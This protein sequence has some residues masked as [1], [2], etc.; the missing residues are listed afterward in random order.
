[1]GFMFLGILGGVIVGA[2]GLGA[3][4]D[5]LARRRG[6]SVTVS[7]PESSTNARTVEAALDPTRQDRLGGGL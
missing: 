2:I 7:T 1:M 5:Y 6:S 3:L 4:Y